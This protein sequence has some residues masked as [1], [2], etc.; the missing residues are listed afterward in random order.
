MR[1]LRIGKIIIT[2]EKVIV[3]FKKQ[4]ELIQPKQWLDY[5][6]MDSGDLRSVKNVISFGIVISLLV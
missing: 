4:I 2:P 3:P 6:Q 5:P 1:R